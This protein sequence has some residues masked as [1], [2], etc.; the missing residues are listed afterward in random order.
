MQHKALAKRSSLNQ[1][2][3]KTCKPVRLAPYQKTARTNNEN[4]TKN[5]LGV[6]KWNIFSVIV[7]EW[8]SKQ[9]RKKSF[10]ISPSS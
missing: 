2:K 9:L 8:G 4:G 6:T 5:I 1:A 10:C 7:R 3:W